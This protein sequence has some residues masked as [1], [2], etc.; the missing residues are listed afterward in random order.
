MLY[1]MGEP[2]R[3]AVIDHGERVRVYL[4]VGQLLPGM[5][6]LIRRLM[7]NTSNTSFL[8]QTYA[9]REEIDKLIVSP[10][11][12]ASNGK[13]PVR[14]RNAPTRGNTS[15]FRNEPPTDFADDENRQRFTQALADVRN[16]FGHDIRPL[17]PDNKQKPTN[18]STP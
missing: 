18:G 17:S 10:A 8:R 9:D 3:R 1:G 15:E 13:R 16:Q 12:K 6:Y 7:E 4:P 11:R 14:R 5:A 2:I